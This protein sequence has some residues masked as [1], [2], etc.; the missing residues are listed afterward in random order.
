MAGER[1]GLR[2]LLLAEL[3]RH[4]QHAPHVK[5]LA[6]QLRQ[7][8]IVA[9]EALL[10]Q[11]RHQ[12]LPQVEAGTADR[13]VDAGRGPLAGVAVLAL[14]QQ[15]VLRAQLEELLAQL[16]IASE[17]LDALEDGRN[18]VAAV[19]VNVDVGDGI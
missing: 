10:D 5:V 13:G 19:G 15:Q 2:G 3:L 17:V 14:R 16:V 8:V 12:H 9:V 18:I 7:A 6:G 4:A 11:G 1:P